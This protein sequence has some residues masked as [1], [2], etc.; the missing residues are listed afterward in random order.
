MYYAKVNWYNS[1]DNEDKIDHIF[2]FADDWNEAMAKIN[3]QFEYINSVEMRQV[4]GSICD[5]LFVP[6]EY[7]EAIIVENQV[8]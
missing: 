4:V 5:V 1:Y 3:S 2:L 7:C 8:N 6:S